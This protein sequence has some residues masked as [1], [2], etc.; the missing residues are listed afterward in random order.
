M[1]LELKPRYTFHFI[2][3]IKVGNMRKQTV[4]K[5]KKVFNTLPDQLKNTTQRI[6]GKWGWVTSPV[7]HE[8]RMRRL[9]HTSGLPGVIDYS[10]LLTIQYAEKMGNKNKKV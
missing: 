7:N 6:K 5:I 4:K 10:N 2:T 1:R 8:K 9:Y 3:L